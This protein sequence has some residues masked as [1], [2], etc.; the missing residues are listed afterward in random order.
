MMTRTYIF[1]CEFTGFTVQYNATNVNANEADSTNSATC[2]LDNNVI[3]MT[4]VDSFRI[5]NTDGLELLLTINNHSYPT[6]NDI[7]SGF[8]NILEVSLQKVEVLDEH[9]NSVGL[10]EHVSIDSVKF[11]EP[12]SAS[13]SENDRAALVDIDMDKAIWERL[14]GATL[15]NAASGTEDHSLS[16]VDMKDD[17]D[18]A[19]DPNYN[20]LNWKWLVGIFLFTVAGALLTGGV[21]NILHI[22]LLG[23]FS[24]ISVLSPL[25]IGAGAI[26]IGF[27]GAGAMLLLKRVYDV[28]LHCSFMQKDALERTRN[29][30]HSSTTASLTSAFSVDPVTPVTNLYADRVS[31]LSIH[32]VTNLHARLTKKTS[33]NAVEPI[34]FPPDGISCEKNSYKWVMKINVSDPDVLPASKLKKERERKIPTK[35]CS[36]I[37]ASK[38]RKKRTQSSITPASAGIAPERERKMHP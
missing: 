28:F 3:T 2:T 15:L 19:V 22:P 36:G 14:F 23:T 27:F 18:F 16:V 9:N 1:A 33:W 38:G 24:S 17:S 11:L 25:A 10:E 29:S 31:N 20:K 37:A 26:T 8:K 30:V 4:N 34:S 7:L 35:Q 21:S 32:H 6:L 12:D 5:T 13:S